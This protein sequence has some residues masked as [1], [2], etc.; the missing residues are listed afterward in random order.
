VSLVDLRD[1]LRVLR[2]RWLLIAVITLVAVGAAAGATLLTTPLYKST[3]TVFVSAGDAQ[4][5]LG[6]AY[7]G[8]LLSQQ[9]VQSYV[10]VA[11]TRPI[12]Q[13]IVDQ[14]GLKISPD[15][16]VGMM[17]VDNPLDTVLLNLSVSSPDP[18]QAQRIAAAWVDQLSKAV[19]R[20]EQSGTGGSSL[21]KIATIEPANFPTSPYSPR[22]TINLAL[23]LLV[24]LAIGIGTAVLLETLDTRVKT[25]ASLPQIAGAPLLGAVASDGEIPKHPLVVRDRPHSPQAEAFRALRTNLQFVDVDQRPRS[26][27]VTS[28]V[29]REGKSTVAMNLA[30]A[31]AEAGTPVAL[32]DADLRRPTL[33]DRLGLEGS[34]G[35]TDVLIGKAGIGD[36]IQRFGSTGKLWVLTSG[37]LPPNPSEML[38][39]KHMR[40]ALAELVRVTTVIIDAPPLLPVTDAAVLAGQTDGAILVTAMGQ[41]RRE[42]VRNAI[43]RLESVGGRVLGVVANRASTRGQEGYAYAYGYYGYEAK[44]RHASDEPSPSVLK[45]FVPAADPATDAQGNGNGNGRGTVNGSANGNGHAP[46]TSDGSANGHAAVNGSANGHAAAEP[47]PSIDLTD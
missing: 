25:V 3:T 5:N 22:P 20:I 27:V 11:K 46:V 2:S 34:A 29:P 8:S 14:L 9:R 43:E 40:S 47:A 28:A 1:Y 19:D 23:G 31:L 37:T 24:G 12:A 45:P 7:T 42:Q 10:D 21:F 32:V 15:A 33:A 18:A 16:V 26:I 30:I 44:G 41:T 39:S 4:S 13:G 6:S 17:S 35:L 38:G 36:V